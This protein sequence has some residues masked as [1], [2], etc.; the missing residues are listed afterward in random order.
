MP[1]TLSASKEV[2]VGN[3]ADNYLHQR[4]KDIGGDMLRIGFKTTAIGAGLIVGGFLLAPVVPWV[5]IG[6][7]VVG[8]I[9][10]SLGIP[11]M[12]LGG[13]KKIADSFRRNR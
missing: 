1:E 9:A 7:W 6:A 4:R 12:I 13:L 5:G 8:D 3:A 11:T 2:Q 10:A